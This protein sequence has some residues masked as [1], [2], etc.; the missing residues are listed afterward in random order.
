MDKKSLY[1]AGR[2]AG[3]KAFTFIEVAIALAI[4]SIS[5]LALIRLHLVS[6]SLTD[7]AQM[8]SQAVFLA[9]EKIAEMLA[10]GYPKEGAAS[11]AVGENANC[12][13]WQ[14]EVTPLQ[15][16]HLGQAGVTGLRKISV[17]VSWEQGSGRKS[18]AMSTYVA[19]RK[20]Q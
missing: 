15:L 1:A 11:G 7:A 20:L 2:P 19:D 9:E 3:R 8:T 16:P 5:L 4:V 10:Y 14:T 17:S 18:I 12:L 13:H 6:V